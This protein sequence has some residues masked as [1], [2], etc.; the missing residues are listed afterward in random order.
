MNRPDRI[1]PSKNL[2]R[3]CS[4]ECGCL[5]ALDPKDELP[6]GDYSPSDLIAFRKTILLALLESFSPDTVVRMGIVNVVQ[7]QEM[8]NRPAV[9]N[10][11]AAE[12]R[13]LLKDVAENVR[14]SEQEHA[15]FVMHLGKGL[16][17][18]VIVRHDSPLFRTSVR[19]QAAGGATSSCYR[20][21]RCVSMTWYL[22]HNAVGWLGFW[23]PSP[24]RSLMWPATTA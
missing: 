17:E 21:S 3:H 22:P 20:A 13:E 2:Y 19:R 14:I 18:W 15:D 16:S 5:P 23:L 12:I 1:S 24:R 7:F 9:A 10:V 8:R 6:P 11:T 4:Q